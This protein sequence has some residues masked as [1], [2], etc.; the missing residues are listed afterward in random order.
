[1]FVAWFVLDVT[2]RLPGRPGTQRSL[3]A[4]LCAIPLLTQW[5]VWTDA[6]R[7]W[8]LAAFEFARTGRLT[9]PSRIAFGP[10]FGPCCWVSAGWSYL[11]ILGSIS[12][13]FA[14]TLRGGPLQRAQGRAIAA[15]M[16]ARRSRRSTRRCSRPTPRAA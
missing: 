14:W 10:S 1:M 6:D 3:L 16:A 4:V 11:L 8:M 7:G 2:G 9:H 13:A 15:G 12:L 5:V